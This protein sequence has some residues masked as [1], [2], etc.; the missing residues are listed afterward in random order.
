MSK[1]FKVNY[2]RSCSHSIKKIKVSLVCSFTSFVVV[3]IT[4]YKQEDND[5]TNYRIQENLPG[6]DAMTL[7]FRY[8]PRDSSNELTR[9]YLIT[10]ADD[11]MFV[12]LSSCSNIWIHSA[13]SRTV[14]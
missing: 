13:V 6:L 7:C 12:L 2:L 10:I 14:L 8:K 9:K 1:T 3:N 4:W 11:S 5:T